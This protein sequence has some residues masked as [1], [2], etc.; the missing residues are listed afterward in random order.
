M[1]EDRGSQVNEAAKK[2][3]GSPKSLP[4]GSEEIFELNIKTEDPLK[5]AKGPIE[6]ES[7]G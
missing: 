4:I 3:K 6:F 2:E 7:E 1:N 5:L